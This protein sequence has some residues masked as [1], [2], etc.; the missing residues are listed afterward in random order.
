[1][2]AIGILLSACTSNSP[3]ESFNFKQNEKVVF[4]GNAF[5]EN[6][7]ANGEIETTIS[8]CFPRKN[9]T[10]RNIGWSGDNVYAHSRA[11][12]RDGRRFGNS[13]EGFGILIKQIN[14]LKPDKIFI[15][16]GFNESFDDDTGIDDFGKGLN[17]LLEMLSEQCPK[18]ILISTLPMENG[19]GIAAEHIEAQNKKLKIHAETTCIVLVR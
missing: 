15:A 2:L 12:A 9:I 19:F 11:R 16:Y 6:A 18:L 5:F 10:F 7:I 13:E 8:L 14:A 17:H 1:M 3:N 4:L